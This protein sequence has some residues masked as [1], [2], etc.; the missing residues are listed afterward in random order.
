MAENLFCASFTLF[1]SRPNPTT[2]A[3]L[4]PTPARPSLSTKWWNICAA[5]QPCRRGKNQ[6]WWGGGDG[7]EGVRYGG[8]HQVRR[9]GTGSRRRGC[10]S[11][12]FHQGVHVSYCPDRSRGAC[13]RLPYRSG[14]EDFNHFFSSIGTTRTA[15]DNAVLG[16]SSTESMSA[17]I[18]SE[19][20]SDKLRVRW[21]QLVY[22]CCIQHCVLL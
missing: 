3:T 4:N 21:S 11:D 16:A 14:N 9:S 8:D 6:G 17:E 13:A 19:K 10:A 1:A 12:A 18:A 7:Q 2:N 5:R 20:K 15:H 22:C